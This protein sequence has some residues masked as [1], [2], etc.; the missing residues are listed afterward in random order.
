MKRYVIVTVICLAA[1]GGFTFAEKNSLAGDYDRVIVGEDNG[2]VTGSF[3]DCTGE[4]KFEC[5][6]SF[7]G[8]RQGTT[9]AIK[10]YGKG[11]T[12]A[13]PGTVTVDGKNL[14]LKLEILPGGCWNVEPNLNKTGANVLRNASLPWLRIATI[15]E[16]TPLYDAK[17]KN[18][19]SRL[20]KLQP[21]AVL[22]KK[23]G[24]VFIEKIGQRAEKGWIREKSLYPLHVK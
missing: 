24:W 18:P 4:C 7:A 20:E 23:Q 13:I 15:K 10:A 3:D 11:S 19:R 1:P 21:I 6:F 14:N 22:E 17:H 12:E 16:E 2:I 8:R 9:F 5:S